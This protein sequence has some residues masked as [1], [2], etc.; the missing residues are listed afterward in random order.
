M[1]DFKLPRAVLFDAAGTLLYPVPPVIEVYARVAGQWGYLAAPGDVAGRYHAAW[2]R[3]Q[4]RTPHDDGRTSEAD[5]RA[6]WRALVAEVFPGAAAIDQIFAAL[7]THFA[8]PAHWQLFDDVV[9]ALASLRSAGIPWY[10]ASNFDARLEQIC[11]GQPG[12]VDCAGLFISS[13]IGFRKPASGFFSTVQQA[14]GCE[15]G[16]LLL[17]GDDL[18]CDYLAARRCGWRALLVDRGGRRQDAETIARLDELSEIL[19]GRER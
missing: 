16:E 14:L 7:W 15:P 2:S 19:L 13:R 11:R 1:A 3:R 12:L 8:Q 5:E 6:W 17:V 4:A 9:P 10:I 18:E